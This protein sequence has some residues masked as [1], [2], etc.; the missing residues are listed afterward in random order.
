MSV[1]HHL[2]SPRAEPKSLIRIVLDA[3]GGDDGLGANVE[4]ARI[5]I[6]SGRLEPEALCL[7]GPEAELRAEMA[8]QGLDSA[9]EVVDAPDELNGESPVDALRFKKG[10]PIFVGL[11]LLKA[12]RAAGFVSAGSTGHVVAT[13]T[14]LLDRLPNV[15]RPGIA[16]TIKSD[17]G[18]VTVEE[19]S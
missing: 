1:T 9:V 14:T 16:A 18:P 6:E 17:H 8:R 2:L 12:G 5:A 10:N 7:V 19:N 13:A 15:R 11:S 4:G 3:T